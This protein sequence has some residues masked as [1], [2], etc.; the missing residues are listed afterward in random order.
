MS[1]RLRRS[2]PAITGAS[3]SVLIVGL[4]LGS[5]W[6]NYFPYE[7]DFALIRYSAV[8][9]SPAPRTWISEGY[10]DYF[11]NDPDCATRFFGMVRPVAN[12]THYLESLFYSSADG[13]LL[14]LSNALCWILSACLV[15]GIARRLGAS[16]WIASA[17]IPL[18]ALSPTWY[19]LLIHS[20]FR[21]N[22]LATCCLLAA[23]YVLL[24]KSV[25]HSHRR[26]LLAG[27]FAALAVGSHEQSLDKYPDS[28]DRCCMAWSTCTVAA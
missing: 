19:R 24:K 1:I 8:Q 17:G 3:A 6:L 5:Y 9:N 12:A 11:A 21:T 22:G 14:M 16:P 10:A 2:I 7:D 27:M 18:Y 13:P 26:V 15:Y 28:R 25:P 20:S 23:F 4:T